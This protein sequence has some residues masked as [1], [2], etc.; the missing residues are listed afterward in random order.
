MGKYK[1]R[2]LKKTGARAS[3][4]LPERSQWQWSLPKCE[5]SE[6]K[7]HF[8][9]TPRVASLAGWLPQLCKHKPAQPPFPGKEP[10]SYQLPASHVSYFLFLPPHSFGSSNSMDWMPKL[11]SIL[12]FAASLRSSLL[13][14]QSPSDPILLLLCHCGPQAGSFGAALCYSL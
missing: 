3:L 8:F 4:P 6:Q 5:D 10:A 13:P 14:S 11:S 9:C 1:A 2:G 7:P 12:C